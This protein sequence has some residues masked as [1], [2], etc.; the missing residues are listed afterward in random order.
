[1]HILFLCTTMID[2]FIIILKCTKITK[3][4]IKMIFMLSISIIWTGYCILLV[5]MQLISSYL[6]PLLLLV[7]RCFYWVWY[8]F[9]LWVLLGIRLLRG[10]RLYR[11]KIENMGFGHWEEHLPLLIEFGWANKKLEN[12]DLFKI[13]KH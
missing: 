7:G 9:Q 5:L 8:H 4:G 1:M 11:R 6:L 3:I 13:Y 2:K 12:N 10:I